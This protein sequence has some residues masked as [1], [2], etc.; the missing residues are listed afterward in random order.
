MRENMNRITNR[1]ILAAALLAC[2]SP[3]G[4][5][6]WSATTPAVTPRDPRWAVKIEK[7]GLPNLHQ[8][9]PDLYRGAQPTA[10]GIK[11][12]KE[13]GIKTVIDLRSFHSD[14]DL[15]VPLG[16]G[17][18]AIE[19]KAWHIET[20]DVVKFLKIVTDKSRGPFFV[21]CQH[22]ADRTGTQCAMYRI[23][24]QGWS[25]EDAL[26][27]MTG[28]GFGFHEIW[29]NIIEFINKADVDEIKREA[30]IK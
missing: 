22:G 26:R 24:V 7:P 23:A 25:K 18:E 30:G 10:E 6:C 27:E 12:L 5:A 20:R 4:C 28:G 8:V 21:H 2:L 17:F 14:R 29:D 11:Q 13:M 15:V 3:T 9:S 1:L 16:M 19:M